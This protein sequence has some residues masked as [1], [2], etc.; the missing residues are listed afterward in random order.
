MCLIIDTL[1]EDNYTMWLSCG[2]TCHSYK[3]CVLTAVVMFVPYLLIEQVAAFPIHATF[4]RTTLHQRAFDKVS[5][6]PHHKGM[7]TFIY[8]SHSSNDRINDDESKIYS[9]SNSDHH[10]YP[11]P[12]TRRKAF[13]S[14]TSLLIP[15]I[16]ISSQ[17]KKANASKETQVSNEFGTK[18]H[19][20]VII[21]GGGRTGMAIAEVCAKESQLYSIPLTRTGR[22]PFQIIKLPP[23]VKEYLPTYSSPVDVRDI[24]SITK[25]FQAIQPSVVIYAASASKQGGDSFAVDSVGVKNVATVCHDIH[26]DMVLI[27]A[28]AVDRPQSKSFQITNTLGGYLNQIM[29]AKL[30]G[31]AQMKNIMG[32]ES[33][34][35]IRPGV[36]LNGKSNNKDPTDSKGIELN[37]GDLIGGGLSRDELARVVVGSIQSGKRGIT[38]E[39]YR[40]STATKLQ[41]EFPLPSGME[42][43]G[44]TYSGLFQNAKLDGTF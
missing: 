24:S 28:L 2:Y 40:A 14:L 19:P 11:H 8:G 29:D 35:I 39:A 9:N 20:I 3:R 25:A 6:S 22:D 31:E 1:Q 37:Q 30:E 16:L 4:F 41:P 10:Y 36:L 15:P 21:G 34:V 18:E 33:Y 26:A 17:S 44:G 43:T 23:S 27:S 42:L 32:N 7:T 12:P 13:F 38:V 5:V